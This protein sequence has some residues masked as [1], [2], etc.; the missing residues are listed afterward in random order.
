MGVLDFFLQGLNNIAEISQEKILIGGMVGPK[1]KKN[2]GQ[3]F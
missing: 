1:R 2:S 3:I